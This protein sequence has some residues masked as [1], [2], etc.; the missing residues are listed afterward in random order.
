M[1]ALTKLKKV[2]LLLTLYTAN[3]CCNDLTF[4]DSSFK[5]NSNHCLKQT[6]YYM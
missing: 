1:T 4:T 6:S 5:C 2:E 3:G